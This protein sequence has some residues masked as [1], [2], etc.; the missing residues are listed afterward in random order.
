MLV[1]F[2]L[3]RRLHLATPQYVPSHN[4]RWLFSLL[5][6]STSYSLS[7]QAASPEF[8]SKSFQHY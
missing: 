1:L 4:S 2:L 8:H 6:T 7:R 5:L 3:V